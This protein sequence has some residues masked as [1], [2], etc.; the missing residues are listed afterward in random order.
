M[1][2][3]QSKLVK[4]YEECKNLADR[5]PAGQ[6]LSTAALVPGV[7]TPTFRK[8]NQIFLFRLSDFG[9][10]GRTYSDPFGY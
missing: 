2:E 6:R 4:I 7:V 5:R 3:K 9:Q 10:L 8:L 1:G